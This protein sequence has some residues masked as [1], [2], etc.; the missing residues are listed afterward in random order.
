MF[1]VG[2]ATPRRG[3]ISEEWLSE[4]LKEVDRSQGSLLT[5][6]Q[7]LRQLVLIQRGLQKHSTAS[8]VD[9]MRDAAFQKL[10]SSPCLGGMLYYSVHPF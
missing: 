10:P 7:Q 9:S 2:W 8:T 6:L 3:M 1:S 4:A 5:V